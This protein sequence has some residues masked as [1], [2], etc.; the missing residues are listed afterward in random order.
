M[1][2]VV[3]AIGFYR[4]L[5]LMQAGDVFLCISYLVA[6]WVK[7]EGILRQTNTSLS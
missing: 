7:R 3:A 6:D 2:V 4:Y 5:S 1:M